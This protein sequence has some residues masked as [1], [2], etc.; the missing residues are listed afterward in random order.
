MDVN[1]DLSNAKTVLL[2]IISNT[3]CTCN[4]IECSSICCLHVGS[5]FHNEEN[6]I[7]KTGELELRSLLLESSCFL[8][9]YFHLY[10]VILG[11][12]CN[13]LTFRFF[14][15]LGSKGDNGCG[16]LSK[17]S[18]LVIMKMMIN[19]LHWF[20]VYKELSQ[21]VLSDTTLWSSFI[22]LFIH[23][24][25]IFWMSARCQALFC[26]LEWFSSERS[27]KK[28]LAFMGFAF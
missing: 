22:L 14:C 12:L 19:T 24:T 11:E 2:V 16:M 6:N 10:C 18:T 1:P 23:L 4:L 7:E 17:F 25:N 21:V 27:R 5:A 20:T 28:L 15:V 26:R 3:N 13:C 9:S 8:S